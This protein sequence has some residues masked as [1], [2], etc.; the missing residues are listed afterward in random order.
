PGYWKEGTIYLY[1]INEPPVGATFLA[2]GRDA[3]FT[4][5]DNTVTVNLPETTPDKYYVTID[6]CFN[7]LPQQTHL[8]QMRNGQIRL[9]PYQAVTS[10]MTK[11]FEPYAFK[12]WY[13][14]D[15]KI[16]YNLYLT[17]GVYT[18][19]AEYAAI[20]TGELYFS[21]N[22]SVHTAAYSK[23]DNYK[24]ATED[25]DNYITKDF[26][27]IKIH[28]PQSGLYRLSIDRN[29]EIPDHFNI[30]NVRSFTL[31][32]EENSY[33]DV[34]V[35]KSLFYPNPVRDGYFYCTA[36]QGESLRIYDATGR[37]MKSSIVGEDRIDVSD[38]RTG[39]YLVA[40]NGFKTKLIILGTY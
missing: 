18:V 13:R 30:I 24:S 22:G 4:W 26:S 7:H 3:N 35:E 27:N 36:P 29:A 17:P 16:R 15:H 34:D 8:P 40:G 1:G 25:F 32:Y 21:I 5:N 12:E 19:Q 37:Q 20:E 9:T 39:I 2:D 10:G 11:D 38:L 6:L 14:K 31:K 23:T 33:I 28:I